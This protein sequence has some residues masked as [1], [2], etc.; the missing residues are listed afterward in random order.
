MNLYRIISKVIPHREQAYPTVGNYIEDGHDVRIEVSN[1]E[2]WKHFV[3]ITIHELIEYAW[4]K[5]H[6]V[7]MDT[8]DSFD[9]Q[10]EHDRSEGK[11]SPTEEPGDHPDSPY[12]DGHRIATLVEVMIAH[13]LGVKWD[14][15][16]KELS[17][18]E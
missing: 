13:M 2:S 9:I 11:H 3:L 12:R 18:L 6:G 7:S 1:T 16:E 5:H 8:I 4:A 10:F 15:Y 17:E 14:E